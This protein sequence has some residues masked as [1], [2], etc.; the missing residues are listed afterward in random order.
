[1]RFGIGEIV[2]G[3]GDAV[4]ADAAGHQRRGVDLSFREQAQRASELLNAPT[5]FGV[6]IGFNLPA[7]CIALLI[8]AILVVTPGPIVTLVIA[9]GATQGIR[10][11]LVTVA[12]E[13]DW[14]AAQ[15]DFDTVTKSFQIP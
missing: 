8:T 3:F 4:D 7:F 12:G 2:E 6:E 10:A 11:A 15:T 14:A 9:T 13:S 5:I 1:M